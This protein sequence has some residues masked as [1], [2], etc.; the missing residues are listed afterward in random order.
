M[1]NRQVKFIGYTDTETN[2]SFVFNGVTVFDGSIPATGSKATP[3]ELFTFDIDQTL[4]GNIA[5]SLT[6]TSGSVTSVTISANYST[7]IR[8]ASVDSDGNAISEVTADDLVNNF[9]WI[10]S[11]DNTS[12]INIAIDGVAY[13][14]GEVGTMAGAW[15]IDVASGQT[16]VCDYPIVA[17]PVA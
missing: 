9:E 13:D 1:A 5:S 2:A 12:K 14:K 15:H 8:P 16:F 11:G 4:S 7:A 3:V 17:T 10:S 6:V